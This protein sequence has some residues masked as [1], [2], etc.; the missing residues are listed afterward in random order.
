M[1]MK[2]FT[3][4]LN[5]GD[6]S[7]DEIEATLK[8]ALKIASEPERGEERKKVSVKKAPWDESVTEAGGHYTKPV[9][10][11]I[12]EH[13]IEKVMHELLTA[14]DADV[15]QDAMSRMGEALGEG[16][17]EEAADAGKV[18]HMEM[19]FTDR[20]GGETSMEVEVTLANGK[21]EVTRG[22]PGPEDDMYW[23]DADIDEQ[24]RDAMAD[25]SVISWM[26]EATAEPT[27]ELSYL[28]KLAGI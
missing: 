28:K 27:Q 5:E 18:G 21:L 14:L 1:K 13:G 17:G 15:I 25:P 2:S 9:Y 7:D 11:M 3:D 6:Q 26:N 16:L 8:R 22:L 10:D 19:F 24:L 23:D 4:Y 20:D 12:E